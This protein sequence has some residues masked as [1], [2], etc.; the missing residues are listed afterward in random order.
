MLPI[1]S[2]PHGF[3][4]P[5]PSGG[6][7]Q[8]SYGVLG[9]RNFKEDRA[10]STSKDSLTTLT[11]DRLLSVEDVSDRFDQAQGLSKRISVYVNAVEQ[12]TYVLANDD[13]DEDT[14]K[15]TG[16]STHYDLHD[17]RPCSTR[18]HARE[19]TTTR[20][21]IPLEHLSRRRTRRPAVYLQTSDQKQDPDGFI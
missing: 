6:T 2:N 1:S 17:R 11:I 8:T 3:G 13:E 10:S 21:S 12:A 15:C 5:R 16:I 18:P 20:P 9:Q 7:R 4:S 19:R 14:P